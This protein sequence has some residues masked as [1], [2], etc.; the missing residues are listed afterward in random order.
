MFLGRNPFVSDFTETSQNTEISRNS[1]GKLPDKL[2]GSF[3]ENFNK[4]FSFEKHRK[5]LRIFWK[6]I[7][8]NFLASKC[9]RE[10]HT[11]AFETLPQKHLKSF[12]RSKRRAHRAKFFGIP[13]EASEKLQRS[14]Q[15]SVSEASGKLSEQLVGSSQK[16]SGS[17]LKSSKLLE[18]SQRCF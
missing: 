13:R 16:L 2:S 3:Q 15:V 4:T 11:K 7:S 9:I 17:S 5:V 1:Y 18:S 8:T 10:V 6:T 12:E 14:S